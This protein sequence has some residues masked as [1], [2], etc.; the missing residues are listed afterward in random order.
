[1]TPEEEFKKLWVTHP[2]A[3]RTRA[4]QGIV[5]ETELYDFM[6]VAGAAIATVVTILLSIPTM[7]KPLFFIIAGS[8]I[9]FRYW[10]RTITLTPWRKKRLDQINKEFPPES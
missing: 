8:G 5:I 9:I 3:K 10:L 6:C 1:M 4:L 2:E 7:T